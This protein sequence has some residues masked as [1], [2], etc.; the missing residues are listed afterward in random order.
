[1]AEGLQV[2]LRVV[3]IDGATIVVELDGLSNTELLLRP[4]W[5]SGG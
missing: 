3:E 4:S 5:H 2:W 1:M